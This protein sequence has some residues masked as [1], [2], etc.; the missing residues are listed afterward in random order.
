MESLYL[1]RCEVFRGLDVD[2][3]A[4]CTSNCET[5]LEDQEEINQCVAVCDA[6][7]AIG[8]DDDR[9]GHCEGFAAEAGNYELAE[10][11]AYV[12]FGIERAELNA[13]GVALNDQRLL[14]EQD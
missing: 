11:N 14:N 3:H 12:E 5:T 8:A 4:T 13:D 6:R 9:I 7:L 2:G 1:E 10:C